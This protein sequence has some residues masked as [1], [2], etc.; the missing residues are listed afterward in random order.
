ML[1]LLQKHKYKIGYILC[2]FG[3][4]YTAVYILPSSL[5]DLDNWTPSI[6]CFFIVIGLVLAAIY[7]RTKDLSVKQ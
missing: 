3:A 7:F 4:F 6:A 5:S 2:I 1:S